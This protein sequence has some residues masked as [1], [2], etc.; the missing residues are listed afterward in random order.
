MRQAVAVFL[1]GLGINQRLRPA[2]ADGAMV[3][4]VDDLESQTA[5]A[6]GGAIVGIEEFTHSLPF[7]IHVA[8]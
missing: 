8:G 6:G 1:Q 2:D 4:P 5:V 7:G 3:L